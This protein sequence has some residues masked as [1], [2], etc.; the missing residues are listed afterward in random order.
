MSALDPSRVDEAAVPK[1]ASVVVATRDRPEKL[2]RTLDGLRRQAIG[3]YEVIVV[4]DG[5]DP[6]LSMLAPDAE[7]HLRIVRTQGTGRSEARNVGARLA[8]GEILVFIDD[9]ISVRPDF[10]GCHLGAHDEWSNAL[11]TGAIR[12]PSEALRTPFGRFRQRLEDQGLPAERGPTPA[13]GFCAAGNTS[14]E[15]ARFLDLGGFD[16]ALAS[17]EDQ[18]LALRHTAHGGLCCYVP[19]AEAIHDDDAL[20]IRSYCRRVEWGAEQL[21]PFLQ[22]HRELP[23]NRRRVQLNGPVDWLREP[24]GALLRKLAKVA[25]SRRAGLAGLF[26]IADWFEGSKPQSEALD[27]LYRLL[28]GIHLL[29]GHRAGLKLH[30]VGSRTAAG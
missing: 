21:I 7:P 27:S 18:D 24:P 29:R 10:L 1:R 11:V 16:P 20:D 25:L 3:A 13:A 23:E 14:M 2:A 15:R 28:L 9:D 22:R 12:L 30:A 8:S 4:D 17:A 26:A 6:P 5:S 19:E